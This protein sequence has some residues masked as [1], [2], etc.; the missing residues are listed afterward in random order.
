MGIYVILVLFIILMYPI[1]KKFTKK[2][3]KW[4][5]I[6]CSIFLIIIIGFR[7]ISLGQS[8]TEK[9]YS[10]IFNYF[11]KVDMEETLKYIERQNIEKTFYLIMK[12]FTSTFK[13]FH[14]FLFFICIPYIASVSY[15]IYK[16]SKFP[17]LSYVIFLA[18]NYF[19]LSFTLLRHVT[20]MAFIII[21]LIFLLKDKKMKFLIFV[22]IASLFH[23]TALVFLIA[24]FCDKFR[25]NIK[26]VILLIIVLTFIFFFGNDIMEIIF[27]L[28]NSSHYIGYK[29]SSGDSIGF[30]IINVLLLL[31]SMRY[32][33][34]YTIEN[35]KEA[36]IIMNLQFLTV[37]MSSFIMFIGEAFRM[38]TYFG[39]FS[40]ILVPN[41]IS[42]EKNTRLKTIMYII[43]LFV[44]IGY[45]FGSTII[46]TN[47]GPYSFFRK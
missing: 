36:Q 43:M 21:A 28:I 38:S 9:V 29:N 15:L 12:F 19:S 20:A 27:S 37:I 42:F 45:F 41:S 2:Y 14:L 10:V 35:S 39:I 40:I 13:N 26:Q 7:D 24:Y 17:I 11:S 34:K 3:K 47:I 33:K 18:L 4:Y 22:L 31:F 30:F 25:V 1:L 32:L 5:C 23:K 6:L 16:Y 46:N 8:D 44:F